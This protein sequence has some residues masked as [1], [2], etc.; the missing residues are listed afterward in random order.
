LP[1][2]GTPSAASFTNRYCIFANIYRPKDTFLNISQVQSRERGFSPLDPLLN[3]KRHRTAFESEVLMTYLRSF[4]PSL[5]SIPFYFS[6]RKGLE[7]TAAFSVLLLATASFAQ[8]RPSSGTEQPAP[9]NQ[10]QP[11]RS[12]DLVTI[13]AGTRL[14]LVL[15][16][17]I[18]SRHLRRGDDIYAQV[19]SPVTAG[20]ELAIPAGTFVQGAVDKVERQGSRGE[21]RVQSASITFPDGYVAKISGPATLEISDGYAFPDPGPRRSLWA[22]ALPAAGAG[23]GA[24]IGHSVGAADSSTTSAFPPGCVGGP[25]FCT[26]TTMPVF[27][28]KGKDTVIGAGVGGMIGAAGSFAILFG[29]HHYFIDVGTP[30]EMRLE[31]PVVLSQTEVE[32][33]VRQSAEQP[34]YQ[35]PILPRRIAPPIDDTPPMPTTP[36][37]PPTVIPGPPGP[38]GVPGPPIIIPGPGLE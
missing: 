9:P 3:R 29:S 35:Q 20:N 6:T 25:P 31:H 15:T 28:T 16:Q 27:G 14:S 38:N 7:F 8:I 23:V 22:V 33:A 26:T 36:A 1:S 13:P 11:A 12:D 30:V 4:R 34:G 17:P 18:Q 21:L 24:L 5:P 37:T 32:D 19:T 2:S 10:A